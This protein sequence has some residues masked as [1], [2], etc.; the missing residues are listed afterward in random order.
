MLHRLA[1]GFATGRIP[2]LRGPIV[3]GG[4]DPPAI[5][6]EL[7]RTNQA[8]AC[9]IGS[10]MGLP[11]AASHSCAVLSFEQSPPVGHQD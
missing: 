6:T 4:H 1:N 10:P 2:Q 9:C 3:R 8:P 7:R 5:G 11:L